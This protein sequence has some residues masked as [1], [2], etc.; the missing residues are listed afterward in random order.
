MLEDFF[1]KQE[2][3]LNSCHIFPKNLLFYA[4]FSQKIAEHLVK[5][6]GQLHLDFL[7]ILIE[8]L[9]IAPFPCEHI[10]DLAIKLLSDKSLQKKITDFD[11]PVT[12]EFEKFV[13][14]CC[15]DNEALN[16][17]QLRR[18]IVSAL[19]GYLRQTVGSC[20]ATAP[21][22][23]I[24]K[25]HPDYF[26]DDLLTLSK[27]NHLR[28]ISLGHLV[29]VPMAL[30]MGA[31][32]LHSKIQAQDLHDSFFIDFLKK[33]NIH[34]KIQEKESFKQVLG[35]ELALVFYSNCYHPLL[36]I[37]EYTVAS[38]CDAKGEF[39]ESTLYL[40]LGL[41]AKFPEGLGEFFQSIYQKKLDD[42]HILLLEAQN[43]AYLAHQRLVMAEA[44]AKNAQT[45]NALQRAKSEIIA[46]NYGLHAKTLDY[47]EI[48][49]E[50][51]KVKQLYT[52]KMQLIKE[53]LPEVFQESYDPD[54]ST[55]AH[56]DEDA[57][58]GFRL[59][60]KDGRLTSRLTPIKN[61]DDFVKAIRSFLETL[62]AKM[63][64]SC[65]DNDSK[66]TLEQVITESIQ[67]TSSKKFLEKAYL[68]AQSRHQQALPWAYVSG[69]T[70]ETLLKTYFRKD[71]LKH[72]TFEA[73]SVKELF[74]DLIEY[75][76]ATSDA[77]LEIYRKDPL[78]PL[79][80]ETN[81]HACLLLPGQSCF[82][83]LWDS[84]H[85][86]YTDVRDKLIEPAI[87]LYQSYSNKSI[88]LEFLGDSH[89]DWASLTIGAILE[90]FGKQGLYIVTSY[91]LSHK[92]L[93]LENQDLGLCPI[94]DSNWSYETL[95]IGYNPLNESLCLM[96]Q[97]SL[98]KGLIWLDH[99]EKTPLK[100]KVYEDL[101]RIELFGP[102][103]KI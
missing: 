20:F 40:T 68:R 96:A 79:L 14:L 59:F 101:T 78:A 47:E 66:R 97:N 57:P 2:E 15:G 50:Q 85:F 37:W 9:P 56:H 100:W 61:E 33:H 98:T 72:Q 51:D 103:I 94:G 70:L 55:S 35:E 27:K 30:S 76:K 92:E 43:E 28:R 16:K 83:A 49:K 4:A 53:N 71:F 60:V 63:I 67:F 7:K 1:K 23:Y 34:E 93:A 6:D 48:K 29:E 84:T 90:H 11:V 45:E 58:A 31:H 26:L 99:M 46:A 65:Q 18:A 21:C 95:I 3:L 73:Q 13:R 52:E 80:L 102:G 91:L 54:L 82:Q 74:L 77:N 10:K 86:T 64:T 39:S 22:L 62:E 32:F 41:D 38:F 88:P 19:F 44:L 8:N 75:F 25:K 89:R 42:K 5:D 24:L 87:R 17:S 69:G 36:K 12:A 81:T